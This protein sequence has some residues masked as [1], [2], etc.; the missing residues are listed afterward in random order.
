MVINFL[1]KLTRKGIKSGVSLLRL[2]RV[3]ILCPHSKLKMGVIGNLSEGFH[4]S[5]QI[6]LELDKD[7]GKK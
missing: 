5:A 4:F 6:Q 1:E 2:V 7:K 3:D